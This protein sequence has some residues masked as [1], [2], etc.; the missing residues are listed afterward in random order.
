MLVPKFELFLSFILSIS[1]I[2]AYFNTGFRIFLS[3]FIPTFPRIFIYF[4]FLFSVSIFIIQEKENL[5]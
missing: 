1:S 5:I 3:N 2:N 4:L